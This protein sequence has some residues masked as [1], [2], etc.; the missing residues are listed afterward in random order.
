[1]YLFTIELFIKA[2]FFINCVYRKIIQN[3]KET[4]KKKKD[5]SIFFISRLYI[6]Q[7]SK[8]IN[9]DTYCVP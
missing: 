1:M 9:L 3:S 4:K 8:Y 5:I 2:Y 6:R 7:P